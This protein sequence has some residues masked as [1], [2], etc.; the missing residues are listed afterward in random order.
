MI[1]FLYFAGDDLHREG[2]LHKALQHPFKGA[3]AVVWIVPLLGEDL[4]RLI[5]E[6]DG[7]PLLFESLVQCFTLQIDDL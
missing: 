6:C 1:P 7:D 5:G 3:R 2:V 4:L